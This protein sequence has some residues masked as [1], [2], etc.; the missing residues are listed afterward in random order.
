MGERSTGQVYEG[1]AP[2]HGRARFRHPYPVH[3]AQEDKYHRAKTGQ[4][5]DA[6][7]GHRLQSEKIPEIHRKTFQKW[8]GTA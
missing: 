8:G 7:L 6:P 2:E 1:Q 4:Q 3:G 5:G